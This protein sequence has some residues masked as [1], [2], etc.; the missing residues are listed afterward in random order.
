MYNKGNTMKW[1]DDTPIA[2]DS[3]M[4]SDNTVSCACPHCGSINEREFESD[5]FT[6]PDYR[7]EKIPC[8]DCGMEFILPNVLF[9]DN[10]LDEP[11]DPEELLDNEF[12][13]SDVDDNLSPSEDI[14]YFKMWDD[15]E[16]EED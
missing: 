12:Y 15:E 5:F 10:W 16:S 14:D 13:E 8:W 6:E 7:T 1:P 3:I 11:I 9:D 2:L 4:I